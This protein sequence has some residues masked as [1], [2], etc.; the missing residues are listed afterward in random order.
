[1][2]TQ[3]VDGLFQRAGI[4]PSRVIEIHGSAHRVRCLGCGA[5]Y[6]RNAIAHEHGQGQPSP[7]CR[8]CSG[9]LKPDTVFM[10]EE[11]DRSLL[12]E[13]LFRTCASDL[14]LIIGTTLVVEPVASIPRIAAEKGIPLVIV[15]LTSTPMDPLASLIAREPAGAF[16]GKAMAAMSTSVP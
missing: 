15:N 2:I 9:I 16:L 6:E 4:S 13:A 7:R 12:G 1:V 10:G 8:A 11:V 3:N 5:L 14:L